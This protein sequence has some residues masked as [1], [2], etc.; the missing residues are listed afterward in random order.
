MKKR[1]E[2]ENFNLEMETLEPRQM[3][4]SVQVFAAG[5]MGGE[6]FNLQVGEQTVVS[7]TV[8]EQQQTFT[9]DTNE[10]LTADDVRIEFANDLWDP[11]NNVDR[12][13]IVDKIVIDGVT[14][15]TENAATFSTGT[16]LPEDGITPG[17]R[18][19]ETLHSNG[20]F[21]YSNAGATDPPVD[22]PVAQP[23]VIS[24]DSAT[25]AANETDGTVTITLTRTDGSDGEVSVD[26]TTVDGTAVSGQDFTAA[27]G[28]ITFADGQT[29]A[30][31]VISLIDDADVEATEAFS[32]TISNAVGGATLGA[33][34][35][36][37][38]SLTSDDASIPQPGVISID[39]ATASANET[40]GTVTITLTRTDGSDGEVSVDYTTVDGTAVSG[41][42]FTAASGTITFA[43][44]QTT[45]D[46]VISLID[47]ADVEATEAFSLTISNAVGGA[48]LG[49]VVSQEISLTSDDASIPQPGVI[50][51][52]SATASANETD[53]TVTITLTRTD[54]S[55]GEVSVDYTT[56]DG[57]AVSGQDFTAASGTITFAD[58]QT[59]AD[60]V[61]SLIDDADVEATE[62]FAIEIS[63]P[64]G[65]ATLGAVVSQEVILASDGHHPRSSNYREYDRDRRTRL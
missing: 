25:A 45:A 52:D 10:T 31:I 29:T 30:D 5:Q 47:D 53:G 17:F 7:F 38:I 20:Y 8:T 2:T 56:V 40:D 36:Q 49:A 41:Q 43:D 23:G 21:Q 62:A 6:E 3:L 37:E 35:S 24:I 27:S 18:L 59:T 13:L 1:P 57:T 61:I 50:S 64:A 60:I 39:S 11:A 54:G 51:I 22:P 33:V 14:Y 9:F 34:V 48:T 4:S 55:D 65:G 12:N 28:T 19:S 15:E 46:I 63:N 32:L 26:Y 58:G 44:G 42:D 16:W